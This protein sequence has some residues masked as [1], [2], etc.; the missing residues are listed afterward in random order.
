MAGFFSGWLD[1]VT[2]VANGLVNEPGD[3]GLANGF[4]GSMKQLVGTIAVSIYV[5]ILSNRFEINFPRDVASAALGAGLP[6]TS[7]N[8]TFAAI[9]NGTAAALD[10]VPGMTTVIETAIADGTH[11]AWAATFRT[12]Y[13][14]SLAFAGL[15]LVAACFSADI[16]NHLNNYVS[17]RIAGTAAMEVP[18]ER[19]MK[20]GHLTDDD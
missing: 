3:L 18:T 8:A 2:S 16:D 10:A 20:H 17:R 9:T 13:Y 5:A 6:E 12:V 15:G 14:S 1:I 11:T 4:L 7:L 19:T